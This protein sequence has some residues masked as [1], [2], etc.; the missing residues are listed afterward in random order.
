MRVGFT[1][2][3]A[4]MTESQ[5]AVLRSCLSLVGVTEFHHGDCEGAEA[6]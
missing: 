6:D 1:G 3:I 5:K 4:G 2:T